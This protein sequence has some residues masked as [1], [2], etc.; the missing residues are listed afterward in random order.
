MGYVIREYRPEDHAAVASLMEELQQH[1]ATIDPLKRNRCGPQYGSFYT[2]HLLNNLKEHEK[3]ICLV[4]V[5]DD[6][7]VGCIV[8]TI[9]PQTDIDLLGEFPLKDAR[10]TELVVAQDMRSKGVGTLLMEAAEDYA[11]KQNCTCI[12]TV[13]FSPNTNA[14][15]FYQ[16]LGFEERCVDVIKTL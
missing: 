4:A 14:Y 15:R 7:V 5:A 3:G 16:K 10:I 9:D 12:R 8:M 1:I 11:R 2:D 6:M 13:V